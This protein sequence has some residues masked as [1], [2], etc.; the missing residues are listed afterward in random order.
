MNRLGQARQALRCSTPQQLL[1]TPAPTAARPGT[2]TPD[3]QVPKGPAC[4]CSSMAWPLRPA[5]QRGSKPPEWRV[6]PGRAG[7][8]VAAWLG[9]E[10]SGSVLL[11]GFIQSFF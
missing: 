11:P 9:A 8:R 4:S 7:C 1:Q 10:L 6:V 2:G 5:A 3:G